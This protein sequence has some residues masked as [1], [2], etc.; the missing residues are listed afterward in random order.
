MNKLNTWLIL[1]YKVPTEPSTLRVRV[2]R[3]LKETGVVY[4]QQSVCVAP[5]FPEVK[6]KVKNIEKLIKTNH[7]SAFLLE[8]KEFSS[9]TEKQLIETF[10]E[11]R[12]LEHK[13]F[14]DGCQKFLDELEMETQRQNYTFHEVEENE[15]DLAKLKKWY[16]KI[17]KRDFFSSHML[18]KSKQQLDHCE[19]VLSQFTNKVY[20]SEGH[21]EG[22]ILQKD[23]M[24]KDN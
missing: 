14:M 1:A 16:R 9:I 6:K 22:Q 10:N 19:N 23:Q 13:E 24:N 20:Q 21:L 2:W 11:Q 8:V 5:E 18:L 12:I 4:I 17:V 3:T 7:G 15:A